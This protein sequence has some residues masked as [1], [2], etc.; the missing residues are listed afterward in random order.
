MPLKNRVGN[1]GNMDRRI[2]HR[3]ITTETT[4]TGG[5][6]E[7]SADEDATIWAE[8][9]DT[10]RSIKEGTVG[11]MEVSNQQVVWQ[12]RWRRIQTTDRIVYGGIEYDIIAIHEIGRQ[13]YLLIIT[14]LRG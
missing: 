3:V 10:T 8:R 14:E 13:Q 4:S 7:V 11:G 12:I 6:R 9:I 2:I 5:P 1:I